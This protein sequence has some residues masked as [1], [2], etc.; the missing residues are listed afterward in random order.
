M[1]DKRAPNKRLCTSGL[2]V[3]NIKKSK[4]NSVSLHYSSFRG[5]E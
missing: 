4:I 5:R 3:S 1:I 2:N